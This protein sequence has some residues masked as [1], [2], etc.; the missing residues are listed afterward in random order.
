MS[1][2][3]NINARKKAGTSRSKKNSTISEKNYKNMQSGFK[4]KG[5]YIKKPGEKFKPHTM[6]DKKGK[7]YQANTNKEHLDMKKKGYGHSKGAYLKKAKAG[8]YLKALKNK[9]DVGMKVS[10][11]TLT[12]TRDVANKMDVKDGAYR[13][14]QILSVSADQVGGG[15]GKRYY[16]GE[17]SSRQPGMARRKASM[18]ARSKMVSA[19]Q[20]SIPSGMI[21]TYFDEPKK[22]AKKKGFF[23]RRK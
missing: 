18:R 2:Y 19:P 20:D 9:K 15:S 1:L 12:N 16:L 6:Y 22:K 8:Y 10:S 14:R 17:G 21:P 23:S 5:A 11:K 3:A 4:N 13:Q 7:A